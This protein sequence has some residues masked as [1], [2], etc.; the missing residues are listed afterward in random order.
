V[1]FDGSCVK[2]NMHQIWSILHRTQLRIA[3]ASWIVVMNRVT[4][5][6]FPHCQSNIIN[7]VLQKGPAI[8]NPNPYF[9]MTA[10][11][12][13][14]AVDGRGGVESKINQ[15][16]VVDTPV[17]VEFRNQT[18][19]CAEGE[20]LR[21]ALLRNRM[22]PH[23]GRARVINCRGLGTC[24]TCAVQIV[25]VVAPTE[26]TAL[27]RTRLSLPPFTAAAAALRLSCQVRIA[28]QANGTMLRVIKYDGFWGQHVPRISCDM[29]FELPFGE[30][31]FILDAQGRESS[32][33]AE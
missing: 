28:Q 25:G 18:I 2:K 6:G 3:L 9:F 14:L 21:T 31:E 7:R 15:N 8:R 23:N 26:R 13:R 30:L 29:G 19:N 1:F 33:P 20:L 27:E 24:G 22:T 12:S 4:S 16:K 5:F 11:F 17:D 10:S 32:P